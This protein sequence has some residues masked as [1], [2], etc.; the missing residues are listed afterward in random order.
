MYLIGV[1]RVHI[2]IIYYIIDYEIT[3]VTLH[4]G[5]IDYP[6]KHVFF[7]LSYIGIVFSFLFIYYFFFLASVVFVLFGNLIF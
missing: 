3:I 6:L 2:H 4:L 1:K 7:S 5:F